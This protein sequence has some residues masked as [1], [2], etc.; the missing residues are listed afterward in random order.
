MNIYAD[1]AATAPMRAAAKAEVIECMDAIGNPSSIHAAGK[2]AR[3]KIAKARSEIASL[4]CCFPSEIIFT[5]G[6]TESDNWIIRS[7]AEE[8]RKIVTSSF[9]HHAILH[10]ADFVEKCLLCEVCKVDPDEMG[11]VNPDDVARHIKGKENLVSIMTANNEIGTIQPIQEIT[12]EVRKIAGKAT[13][14][15]TDAVQAVGHIPVDIQKLGVD[16]LSLSAHKF[17]GPKGIGVLYC[18]SHVKVKPILFGGRQE[19][20]RRPG[21]ENVAAIAGMAAALREACEKQEGEKARITVLRDALIR[22]IIEIPGAHINGD[23]RRRLPG[24]VNCRFDG[25]EGETLV[26]LLSLA[27]VFVSSGSACTS[28]SGEPSHVLTAIGQSRNDAF[29][30]VRITIGEETTEE[31]VDKIAGAVKAAIEK[32]RG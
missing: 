18:S 9:E 30:A 32:I 25:I 13:L 29:G 7:A 21:T 27:G 2:I 31:D 11:I 1:Y 10:A 26:M 14:I 19:M 6:G 8:G 16:M 15:H 22:Q 23:Q 5:S 20:G 28:G 17:G 24:N 12:E 3:D 4:L